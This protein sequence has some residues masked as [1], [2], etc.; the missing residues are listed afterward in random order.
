MRRYNLYSCKCDATAGI[1][2]CSHFL[3]WLTFKCIRVGPKILKQEL[4][5]FSKCSVY[6]YTMSCILIYAICTCDDPYNFNLDRQMFKLF[7]YMYI[8]HCSEVR[9]FFSKWQLIWQACPK[10]FRHLCFNRSSIWMVLMQTEPEYCM[11]PSNLRLS[12]GL[13]PRL[14]TQMIRT[15][16]IVCVQQNCKLKKK[17]LY[18]MKFMDFK[19]IQT[20]GIVCVQ[21]NCKLK[22]KRLYNMKFMDFKMIRTRGIVCVQQ[23]CKL[24]E[25]CLYN[26]KFIDSQMIRTRGIVCVQQNCKLKEKCFNNMKFIDTQMIQTHGIVC[27][28]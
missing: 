5:C 12:L 8:F 22:K 21:Q 2:H 9:S 25:K 6:M 26:M 7:Y 27:V 18:N 3:V 11:L 16:G 20:R 23:N 19:M 15:R 28:Q 24:K 10:R 13:R 1:L 14:D 17:R 4:F